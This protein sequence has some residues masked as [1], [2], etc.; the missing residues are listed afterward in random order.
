MELHP[1]PFGGGRIMAESKNWR[2]LEANA[3][4]VA[5]DDAKAEGDLFLEHKDTGTKDNWGAS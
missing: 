3:A 5:N 2:L 1:I 4:D